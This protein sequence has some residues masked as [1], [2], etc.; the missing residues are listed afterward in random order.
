M[1]NIKAFAATAAGKPLTPVE[2]D[3]GPL[4]A[5]QVEIIR[6]AIRQGD[7]DA[8]PQVITAIRET[9]ALDESLER[10]REYARSAQQE[11]VRLPASTHRDALFDLAEYAVARIS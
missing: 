1:A 5:E 7:R 6:T 4:G 2:F 9:D 3:P 10:A 11:L 8:L